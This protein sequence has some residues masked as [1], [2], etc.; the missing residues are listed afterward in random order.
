MEKRFEARLKKAVEHLGGVC[1]KFSP[2]GVNG[3]PDRL[4]LFPVNLVF[5]AEIKSPGERLRPLQAKRK[6][7]LERMGFKVFVID[8]F[9]SIEKFVWEVRH[10][11]HTA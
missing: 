4:I 2:Q 7:Q 10:E 9:T 3:M 8:S 5:F 6:Q 1:L 11:I